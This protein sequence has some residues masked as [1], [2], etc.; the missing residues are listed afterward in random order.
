VGKGY[1]DAVTIMYKPVTAGYSI[2]YIRRSG[3]PE[4]STAP[5][6]NVIHF[7]KLRAHKCAIVTWILHQQEVPALQAVEQG[8]GIKEQF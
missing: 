7:G 1:Y 6:N 5:L 4:E 3:P 2:A 8:R